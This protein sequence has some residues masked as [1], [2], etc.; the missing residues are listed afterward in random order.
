[1]SF[2]AIGIVAKVSED[3]CKQVL[4]DFFS[5]LVE[6]SRRTLKEVK[7]ELKGVGFLHLFKN[8]ELAFQH[9]D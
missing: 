7:I 8:R 5:A 2:A 6:V 3:L 4:T 9:V 1:M